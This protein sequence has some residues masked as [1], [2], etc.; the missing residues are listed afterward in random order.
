MMDIFYLDLITVIRFFVDSLNMR[1]PINICGGI[2]SP[3]V[4]LFDVFIYILL[5]SK[6]EEVIEVVIK[7]IKFVKSYCKMSE[8][9]MVID[10]G[11]II[12]VSN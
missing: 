9:Y 6:T 2:S 12:L 1:F 4:F 7:Y 11:S 8:G 10:W 3:I 5:K